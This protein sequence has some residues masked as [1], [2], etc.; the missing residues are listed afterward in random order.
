MNRAMKSQTSAFRPAPGLSFTAKI[1][2]PVRCAGTMTA[3]IFVASFRV[4]KIIIGKSFRFVFK[5]SEKLPDDFQLEIYSV[6]GA[7]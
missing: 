2:T 7:V 6:A 1:M 4:C 3:Y 5:Q